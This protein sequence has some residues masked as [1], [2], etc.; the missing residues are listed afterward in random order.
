MTKRVLPSTAAKTT[1]TINGRTFTAALG[2]TQDVL[3]ADAAEL[4]ANG[5]M[6]VGN[7]QS[8]GVGATSARPATGL[9]IGAMYGDTTLGYITVYDG[10][11]W[12]NPI[13]G[14]SV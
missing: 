1:T 9:F 4:A 14:A 11:S 8:V 5:Y 13:T 6:V 2:T 3:D 7:S 10:A 12:R